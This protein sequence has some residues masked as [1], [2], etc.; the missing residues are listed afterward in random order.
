MSDDTIRPAAGPRATAVIVEGEPRSEDFVSRLGQAAR[1]NPASAALIAMGTAWLFAGG[2]RVSILGG[3]LSGRRRSAPTVDVYEEGYGYSGYSAPRPF[4]S[5][6]RNEAGF[7]GSVRA[8]ARR[9]TAELGRGADGAAHRAGDAVR[10]VGRAASRAGEGAAAI[11]SDVGERLG[12]AT[13]AGYHGAS[14][15]ARGAGGALARAAREAWQETE[16][17]GQSAREYLEERP[18]AVGALGLAAGVGLA[19]SL[20]RTRTEAEWLGERSDAF[21]AQARRAASSRLEDA[22]RGAD[23]VA[24]RLVRDAEA[25]GF[26]SDAISGAVQE[27]RS[28]LEKVALAAKDAAEDEVAGNADAKKPGKR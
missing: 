22:R 18:F 21:K 11:A 27:F 14:T 17:F 24:K 4:P 5:E 13:Q 26:S 19:L 1:E 2:G 6:A 20:P 23:D 7:E 16:D 28:K 3:R 15:A 12:D 25:H 8:G 10:S 9:G